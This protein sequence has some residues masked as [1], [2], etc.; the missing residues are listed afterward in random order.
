MKAD[1]DHNQHF[2]FTKI[3]MASLGKKGRG[4]LFLGI[5]AVPGRPSV[6]PRHYSRWHPVFTWKMYKRSSPYKAVNLEAHELDRVIKELCARL[7]G[8]IYLYMIDQDI[9]NCVAEEL[10]E[11]NTKSAAK[12]I[13]AETSPGKDI[14]WRKMLIR[15]LLKILEEYTTA[16]HNEMFYITARV[17]SATKIDKGTFH[18]IARRVKAIEN[19][20]SPLPR[21]TFG[22]S[23]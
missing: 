3:I 16:N 1:Y 4:G 19:R 17:L 6:R 12:F 10:A 5:R 18:E 14:F 7:A 20:L 13:S 11:E 21:I 15:D 8:R 9:S 2:E 22:P 23:A